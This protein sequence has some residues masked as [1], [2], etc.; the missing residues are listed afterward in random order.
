VGEKFF[1]LVL[2]L[3]GSCLVFG[4]NSFC[5]IDKQLDK[6][7]VKSLKKFRDQ[8]HSTC[9]NCLNGSCDLK[10]WPSDKSGDA[11][12][13]K[14]LFC[15][16]SYVS[17]VFKMPDGVKKGKSLIT[18]SYFINEKGKI[19]GVDITKVKG[20]MNL[21]QAYK[22]VT[23]FAKKTSFEPLVIEGKKYQVS[24]LNGQ[25]I[26]VVGNAEDLNKYQANDQGIWRN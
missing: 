26:A 25:V 23:S 20:E 16:P 3:T 21:R 19:K 17:R 13:C 24:N 11:S 6:E 1:L 2:L 4:S 8:Y 10:D 15:S 12:V 7:V 14:I 22:Y 18:F 5:S 9:L